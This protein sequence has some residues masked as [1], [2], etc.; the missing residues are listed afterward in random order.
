MIKG[1][2]LIPVFKNSKYKF[3][4]STECPETFFSNG[5]IRIVKIKEFMKKKSFH[6]LNLTYFQ[7]ENEKSI[8]IDT[9]FDYTI[10]KRIK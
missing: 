9:K 7:M 3:A 5:A 2:K 1:K 6:D 4:K 10:A 8:D